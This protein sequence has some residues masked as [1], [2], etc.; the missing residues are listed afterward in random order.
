VK[1]GSK[2]LLFLKKKKQKD[3]S[4][5]AP[6]FPGAKLEKFFGSFFQKRTSCLGC[7]P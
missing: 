7:R 5:F 2:I 6:I 1:E 4:D 3:F